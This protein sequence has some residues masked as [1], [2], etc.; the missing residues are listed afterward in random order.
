MKDTLSQLNNV[1]TIK[2]CTST[3][4]SDI[5][6]HIRCEAFDQIYHFPICNISHNRINFSHGSN[7]IYLLAS[8]DTSVKQ[9]DRL[10]WKHVLRLR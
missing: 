3:Y 2:S 8:C 6:H 10:A 1:E 7:A 5:C 4:N 9:L